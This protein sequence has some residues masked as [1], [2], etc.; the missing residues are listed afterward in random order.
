MGLFTRSGGVRVRDGAS[1]RAEQQ[2][3]ALQRETGEFYTTEIRKNFTGKADA[4]PY[5]TRF[6]QTYERLYDKRPP[7]NP[8]DR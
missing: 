4:R 6:I 7:G 1:I 2:A 3:R 5:E 8:L